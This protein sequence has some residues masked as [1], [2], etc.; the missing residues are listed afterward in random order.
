[1]K[2][3]YCG[4]ENE[5]GTLYCVYCGKPLKRNLENRIEKEEDDDAT[6][7]LGYSEES[8]DSQYFANDTYDDADSVWDDDI[9]VKKEKKALSMRTLTYIKIGLLVVLI[10]LVAGGGTFFYFNMDKAGSKETTS[11][12]T[13]KKKTSNASK[14]EAVT[15]PSAQ[16]KEEVVLKPETTT[17]SKTTTS[18]T[19]NTTENTTDSTTSTQSDTQSDA[20]SDTQSD[21]SASSSD[22]ILPDSSNSYVSDSELEG[23]S[24]DELAKARNEI[25]ARHGYIFHK[26]QEMKNYFESKSWYKGTTS[27]EDDIPLTEVEKANIDKIKA[28]ENA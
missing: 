24:K 1:M 28:Y 17:E 7:P 10:A 5:E 9:S 8:E 19:G 13:T 18:D 16:K 25:Y 11:E 23:L 20:Q 27:N 3:P 21:T 14:Q 4:K 2:C 6:L 26:N 15:K 12:T 22:Y